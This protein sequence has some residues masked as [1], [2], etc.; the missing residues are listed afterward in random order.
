MLLKNYQTPSENINIGIIPII[1][2]T[3]EKQLILTF[4]NFISIQF[5]QAK[6]KIE[7]FFQRKANSFLI[8]YHY[9]IKVSK[10]DIASEFN[11]YLYKLRDI[12]KSNYQILHKITYNFSTEKI[13]NQYLITNY[14]MVLETYK[15]ILIP[16]IANKIFCFFI[17]NTNYG[18]QVSSEAENFVLKINSV[19]I[20]CSN[21]YFDAFKKEL[22]KSK[23]GESHLICTKTDFDYLLIYCFW[24]HILSLEQKI[25]KH[26][27]LS[28]MFATLRENVEFVKPTYNQ[29]ANNDRLLYDKFI[30]VEKCKIF[31]IDILYNVI[32][33]KLCYEESELLIF[34]DFFDCWKENCKSL[35]FDDFTY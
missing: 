1:N 18:K 29:A 12:N 20:H 15:S 6:F 22:K 10:L 28:Q 23:N 19:S 24:M 3:N 8:S 17:S 26:I 7:P 2:V 11:L 27:L 25:Q 30:N 31:D 4:I 32:L 16:N 5:L 9:V 35:F 34:N 14:A 21:L 13:F 33:E